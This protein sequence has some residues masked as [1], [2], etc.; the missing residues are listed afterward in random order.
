MAELGRGREERCES[1][2]PASARDVTCAAWRE[3]ACG[4]ESQRAAALG[5][6]QEAELRRERARAGARV[7]GRV[8]AK[9]GLLLRGWGEE[10]AYVVG[11]E[12]SHNWVGELIGF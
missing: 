10:H 4:R 12:I 11:V 6:A 5:T 1:R 8:V 3:R 9:L 7:V 2:E